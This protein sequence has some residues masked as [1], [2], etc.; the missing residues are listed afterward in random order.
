MITRTEPHVSRFQKFK[1]KHTNEEHN[2]YLNDK[3]AFRKIKQYILCNDFDFFVTFTVNQ[4]FCNRYSYEETTE[5]MKKI[6]KKIQRK[7][8]S[9]KYIYICEKHRDGAF[10]FHGVI[11][12]Y[13]ENQLF[14]NKNG[15][16]SIK[17]FENLGFNSVS[18]IKNKIACSNYITKY[19]TKDC[20]HF[21]N[22]NRYFCSRGLK[23]PEKYEIILD[24]KV[25][26]SNFPHFFKN[27]YIQKAEFELKELT[28]CQTLDLIQSKIVT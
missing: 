12:G 17:E 9:F 13:P 25:D 15:Y 16:F 14:L 4:A 26:L 28:V 6:M 20:Q 19:I 2:S 10:H 27:D 1:T 7:Y 23:K 21:I 8:K 22:G 18:K 5:K 3:R 24:D 11:L